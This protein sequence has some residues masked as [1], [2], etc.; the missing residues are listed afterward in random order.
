MEASCQAGDDIT[1]QLG[2]P[3]EASTRAALDFLAGRACTPIS[4]AGR[5][6]HQPRRSSG[7]RELLT[8]GSGRRAVQREAPGAF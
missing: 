4:A 8:P 5:R 6:D 7:K 1:R 2:D 3:Q